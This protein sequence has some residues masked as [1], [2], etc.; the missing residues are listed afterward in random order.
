MRNKY[1]WVIIKLS[2]K[3]ELK[4]FEEDDIE[5][6]RIYYG[7]DTKKEALEQAK[8]WKW[9]EKLTYNKYRYIVEREDRI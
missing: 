9:C 7:F 5:D 3:N 6:S 2:K 4:L 1:E 8:I